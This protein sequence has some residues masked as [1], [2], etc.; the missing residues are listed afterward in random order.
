MDETSVDKKPIDG[1]PIQ[2]RGPAYDKGVSGSV[3]ENV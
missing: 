1:L 3:P 2:N